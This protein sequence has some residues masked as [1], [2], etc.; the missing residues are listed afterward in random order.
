MGRLLWRLKLNI[1]KQQHTQRKTQTII[2]QVKNVQR[3][4]VNGSDKM[5]SENIQTKHK[6][7][8]IDRIKDFNDLLEISML[9]DTEKEILK[10]H[11]VKD[12]DF[13]FIADTLGMSKANVYKKH[14][15]CLKKLRKL[16]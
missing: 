10:L 9:N 5:N 11:Y 13:G 12:K 16:L 4:D 7:K 14:L 1:Q 2:N 3:V 6:I 15:K 8:E